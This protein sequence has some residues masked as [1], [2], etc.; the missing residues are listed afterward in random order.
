MAV[1]QSDSLTDFIEQAVK[2]SSPATQSEMDRVH[3]VRATRI[4]RE[5]PNVMSFEV[6]ANSK[7]DDLKTFASALDAS[8]EF[9]DLRTP[10]LGDGFS[11]GRYGPWTVNKRY[12]EKRLFA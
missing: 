11:W 3:E 9:I 10:K 4:W 6:S 5:N 2:R 12:G 1:Y 8:Y 7:D